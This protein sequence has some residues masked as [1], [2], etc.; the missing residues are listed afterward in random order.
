MRTGAPRWRT[1]ISFVKLDIGNPDKVPLNREVLLDN[2]AF[3]RAK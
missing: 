3:N 1:P 2:I